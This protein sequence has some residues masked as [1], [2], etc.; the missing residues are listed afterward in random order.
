M[1]A[2]SIPYKFSLVWSVN[3]TAGY[4]GSPIP[5]TTSGAR[6]SQSLGFPPITSFNPG[7]G[8]IPPEIADFNAAFQY[9][10]MWN[11]WQQA[12]GPIFYDATFSTSIG[13][14]PNAATLA[15]GAFTGWWISLADNNTSDPDT[16]GANWALVNAFRNVQV[17]TS[18]DSFTIPIGVHQIEVAVWGGGSGGQGGTGGSGCAGGYA[19]GLF[20]VGPGSVFAV[21]IG[22]GGA[23]TIYPT[24]SGAGGT[25]SFGSTISATGGAAVANVPT[26]GGVGSGGQINLTGQPG[27]DIFVGGP[28]SAPGAPAPMGGGGGDPLGTQAASPGAGGGAALT[29]TSSGTSSAGGGGMCVVR[30]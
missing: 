6:I 9:C 5:P 15:P 2:S 18:S 8:G 11:Q 23:G 20:N 28:T 29:G 13:G 25:T 30:W 22:V 1:L 12:G 4:V 14:Y 17:L 26:I 27:W 3:A 24:P 10:S 16:G 7:A 21:T 19:W